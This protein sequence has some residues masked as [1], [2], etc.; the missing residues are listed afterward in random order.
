MAVVD[1]ARLLD[2]MP[3]P[4]RAAYSMRAMGKAGL[5]DPIHVAGKPYRLVQSVKHDFF[6]A[7]GF[8]ENP[9]GTRVVLKI[10]RTQEFA[11]VPLLWLGQWICRRE[12]RFYGRLAD[13]PAVP[14]VLGLVGQTGFVLEYVRGH[15][16][17]RHA[18]VPDGFFRELQEL[19]FELHRRGIAYVDTNKTQNILVGED[20]HPHLVDF[21]ISWDLHE[22]GDWWL[23]RLVLAHLQKEDLYHILKHKRRMR[24]DELTPAEREQSRRRSLLLRIHRFILWPYFRLRRRTFQRLRDTGRLLPEGS[25]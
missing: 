10:S 19:M 21:Q 7:T 14:K 9:S 20:G 25:K 5:P 23:N 15:P 16:L 17:S 6:A 8:Y 18:P 13:L 22:P 3:R 2:H 12:L 24:P 4:Q 1:E 11:G